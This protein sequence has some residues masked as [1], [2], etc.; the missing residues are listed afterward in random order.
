MRLEPF[1]LRCKVTASGNILENV[2]L[3]A[4]GSGSGLFQGSNPQLYGETVGKPRKLALNL[5]I[6]EYE[7]DSN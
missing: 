1:L 2:K 7:A 3:D 6:S 4:R 5:G